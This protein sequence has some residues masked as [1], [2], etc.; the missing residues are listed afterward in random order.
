LRPWQRREPG[1]FKAILLQLVVYAGVGGVLNLV[2][3]L[4]YA[5]LRE[6]S[7]AQWANAVA[8]VLSTLLGTWGHRRVTF[9]VRGAERTVPHQT[10]GLV[11]LVFGLAVTAGSLWLLEATVE[12]PTRWSEL[13]VLAAANLG[14][15]LVRFAAFR[16][17]MVPTPVTTPP[18]P[19]GRRQPP[20]QPAPPPAAPPCADERVE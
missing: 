19:S 8:L 3:I 2:Y 20:P 18:P 9:G 14:V 7:S 16:S 13:L 10:L 5:V 17:A 4:M 15:G 6:W 12:E 11:M 1:N